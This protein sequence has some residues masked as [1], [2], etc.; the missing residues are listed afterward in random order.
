MAKHSGTG[1]LC[2]QMKMHSLPVWCL[3]AAG[4]CAL[5]QAAHGAEK[6]P[7]GSASAASVA[8]W[9]ALDW[10]K[11]AATPFA[12]VESPTFIVEGRLFLFGGFTSTLAAS[13]QLDVYDPAT[14]SWTRRKDMPMQLTHLNPA[15]DG[16]TIW[17]AGGFKGKHPGP[18]TAE[19]WK[20]DVT[21]DTW[22]AGLPLPEPRAG[23]GLDVVGRRLHYFGGFKSDRQTDSGDHWS[24]PLDGAGE[25]QRE[26]DLPDPRGH[27]SAAVLDG[28]LYA[29]GGTHGH[30][31]TQN[32]VDSCH[33][34]DPATK[35]WTA[36]ASLP[37]G[38]SH[39]ESSTIIHHG[40]ILIIGGRCNQSKPP[41][42]VVG[43]MLEFDPAANAWRV[44]GELPVKVMAPSAGII[45]GRIV[46]TG[47]GL[48]NPRPLTAETW[49]A[50]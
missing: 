24:L 4:A 31:K 44:V 21:S 12:R 40:R 5:V 28:K 16:N 7:D 18:V 19:V 38:R 2:A 50:P 46:V 45:A 15:G 10:K 33:R 36:I 26:A 29:L 8:A 22:T 9:P 6:N 43:D 48:N 35:Q 11:A 20:Y 49:I 32:D 27:V 39:F 37:D 13:G 1:S 30:D 23:G 41:R 17:F 3:V 47:G 14:D 34:F 42:G 25:W